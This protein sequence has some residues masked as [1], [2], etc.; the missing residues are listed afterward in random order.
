M[1]T[2]HVE[3]EFPRQE[4]DPVKQVCAMH[5]VKHVELGLVMHSPFQ[6][7]VALQERL[8][9]DRGK[10]GTVQYFS[11]ILQPGSAVDPSVTM[12]SYQ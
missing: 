9:P 3:L 10:A 12:V 11:V 5:L 2:Q 8:V 6:M 1:D 4:S 7:M